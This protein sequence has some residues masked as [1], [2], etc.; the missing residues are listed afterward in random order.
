MLTGM[1]REIESEF[2]TT[3][4]MCTLGDPTVMV[5]SR[6]AGGPDAPSAVNVYVVVTDG[7][8]STHRESA[9]E[10]SCRGGDNHTV[11]AFSTP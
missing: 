4:T 5:T 8:T 1:P 10:S 2:T 6:V 9:A 3:S 11:F 7:V